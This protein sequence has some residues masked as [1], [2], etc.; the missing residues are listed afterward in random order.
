MHLSFEVRIVKTSLIVCSNFFLSFSLP[1]INR[2]MSSWQLYYPGQNDAFNF[3]F[4]VFPSKPRSIQIEFYNNLSDVKIS[5]SEPHVTGIGSLFYCIQ[6]Q[7]NGKGKWRQEIATKE[8]EVKIIAP[9]SGDHVRV[10]AA[11]NVDYKKISCSQ[12]FG[13]YCK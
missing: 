7:E 3:S 13:K 2:V 9:S 10:C 1:L 11:N 5:W 6:L 4:L 12:S 8:L